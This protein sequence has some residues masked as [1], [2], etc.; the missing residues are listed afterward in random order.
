[1]SEDESTQ[2]I[3]LKKTQ[4]K[5]DEDTLTTKP[6]S[7]RLKDYDEQRNEKIS[8]LAEE[9]DKKE[10]EQAPH[11]EPIAKPSP[12]AVK[13]KEDQPIWSNDGVLINP[14]SDDEN[15]DSQNRGDDSDQE[16]RKKPIVQPKKTYPDF[17]ERNASLVVTKKEETPSKSEKKITQ[18]EYTEF[19]ERQEQ[20][21]AERKSTPKTPKMKSK[22]CPGSKK[23]AKGKKSKIY[24]S[25][26]PSSPPEEYTFMPQLETAD[27]P[28]NG[29]SIVHAEAQGV[30]RDIG[31]KSLEV[32][33]TSSEMTECTF[34]PRFIS[35]STIRDNAQK[36]VEKR[37]RE[38]EEK[39]AK[40]PPPPE[41][42]KE[43]EV[44]CHKSP[45]YSQDPPKNHQQCV[46]VL[47]MFEDVPK[48]EGKKKGKGKKSK[49]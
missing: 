39:M 42:P 43:E 11:I 15:I 14:P 2:K 30:L 35:D 16:Y 37:K 20:L 26:P 5:R 3:V 6:Y 44:L 13:R 38:K 1:M 21:I 17:L 24:D 19:M 18:K 10:R 32:E 7:K 23:L 12:F 25:K 40:N 46:Q 48:K 9:R 41:K 45:K 36:L 22:M 29:I 8:R 47:R 34:Q 49:I 28:T 33:K 4:D 31:M 27:Y